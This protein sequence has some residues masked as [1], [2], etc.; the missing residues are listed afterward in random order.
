MTGLLAQTVGK[1][2]AV[3]ARDRRFTAC[4]G[5]ICVGGVAFENFRRE[6]AQKIAVVPQQFNIP[7]AYSVE[8]VVL[9]GRTPFIRGLFGEDKRGHQM[10]TDALE[11]TG[12]IEFRNRYF[13]ELSGGE[14]QKVVLA[15]LLR[16]EPT[17]LLL[18][19]PTLI[20]IYQPG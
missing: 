16:Q 20:L 6:V 19:E 18:D 2:D 8:E 4:E 1:D 17:L 15:M 11:V 12:M 3:E 7:F 14:R 10:V 5:D 13:N 9:L